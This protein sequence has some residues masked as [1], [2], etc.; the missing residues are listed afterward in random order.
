MNGQLFK[1]DISALISPEW[2][3]ERTFY[4][5]ILEDIISYEIDSD[6]EI[7]AT[8]QKEGCQT[9]K[10]LIIKRGNIGVKFLFD[11][12]KTIESLKSESYPG[13]HL[14]IPITAKLPF[15]YNKFPIW[16]IGL[17]SKVMTTKIEISDL[18]KF[19]RYPLDVTTDIFEQIYKSNFKSIWPN[20][21]KYAVVFSH[22]VDTPWLFQNEYWFRKYKEAEEK[23]NVRS[24]W[25]VVPLDVKKK[26]FKEALKQLIKDGHEIGAHGYD[27]NPALP[28]LPPKK[29]FE[30]LKLSH[31]IISE[32]KNDGVGYRSPWLIRNQNLYRILTEV[33]YLYDSSIPTTD[34]Q[35]NNSLSNNG[36]CS[37]FP[38]IREGVPVIPVTLPPDGLYY[39]LNKSPSEFWNWIYELT[40]NIKKI[41]GV[42][43][44]IT[45]LQPHH[46]A[47]EAM[48]KGYGNFIN[49]ITMDKDAWIPLPQEII[50]NQNFSRFD[51]SSIK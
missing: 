25:Y 41:G 48:L 15:D 43:M 10:P 27:H 33:G 12:K 39:S 22:D 45:H 42:A 11:V 19:P 3:E 30:K 49:K 36:C 40:M 46:S 1:I 5:S 44:I 9:P 4:T 16:L 18:P 28:N 20:K 2:L 26:K 50:R 51:L 14:A 6:T 34:F 37:V 7:L 29:L 23:Y 21:K 47:N 8:Y 17:I 35:R 32:Y 24:A 38:F 13:S 31:D